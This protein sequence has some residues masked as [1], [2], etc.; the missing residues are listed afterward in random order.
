MQSIDA[1]MMEARSEIPVLHTRNLRLSPCS[2]ADR[3]DFIGLELDPEVMLFL[4]GG[5]VARR[6]ESD[7]DSLYLMPRGTEDHVWTARH[8]VDG[9]FV[10]WFCLW[11]VA[12]A[13]AE[14][15]YRLRRAEWG[16]GLASE[17]A[18]ALV[19]W[20]FESAGYDRIT[21]CAMAAHHASRRVLEKIG[22]AHVRTVHVD[23]AGGIPG[24][25]EGEVWYE[26]NRSA[27]PC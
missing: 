13:E 4:N 7:P 19:A 24:G 3:E 26:L 16:K 11:P 25:E 17:G 23:W 5:Q 8:S 2:Q 1:G 18:S 9:A 22:M 12:A 27:M 21:A 10:G 15:G 6:E 20:G 14:L